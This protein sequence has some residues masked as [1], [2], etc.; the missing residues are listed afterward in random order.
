MGS[1]TNGVYVPAI[2]ETG[3]GSAV[4]DFLTRTG[5][6][7][8]DATLAPY[9]ADP[10]GVGDSSSAI[11][12]AIDVVKTT[13]GTVFLPGGIYRIDTGL[14]IGASGVATEGV[15]LRGAGGTSKT[16][17]TGSGSTWLKYNGSS[18]T[19]PIVDWYSS[20]GGGIYN[21]G[22]D[23]NNLANYGLQ[24]THISGQTNAGVA[25]TIQSCSFINARTYNVLIGDDS[26]SAKTGQVEGLNFFNCWFRQSTLTAHTTAHVRH[27]STNSLANNMYGCYFAGD[28]TYP[29]YHVSVVSGQMSFFGCEGAG[30]CGTADFL[31][32]SISGQ[33]P[34]NIYVFGYESQGA[35]LLRT[36][37]SHTSAAVGRPTVLSGVYHGDSN[38]G[39][40]DAIKWGTGMTA[41]TDWGPLV[42]T[43]VKTKQ[44]IVLDSTLAKVFVT[45]VLFTDVAGAF[46]ADNGASLATQLAGFWYD[47]TSGS[48]TPKFFS[49]TPGAMKV[50]SSTTGNRPSATLYAAGAMWYDTTLNKPV[51]TD[52]TNWRDASGSVV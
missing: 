8:I 27:V 20:F 41:V 23:G 39:T 24:I 25:K 37:Y 36:D 14:K 22:F 5:N 48:N 49:Q 19:G 46:R 32:G 9:G 10:T 18:G 11:Q 2:G 40:A 26:S 28:N 45:G 43:G 1:Y 51:F 15:V 16:S 50:G 52:G 13:G 35:A 33:E 47:G 44:D 42:L 3:W 29:T 31:L 30:G 38:L 17:S 6:A 34:G 21:I 7:Y 12:A 4:N